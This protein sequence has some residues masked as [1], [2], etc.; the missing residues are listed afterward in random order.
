[1]PRH[2]NLVAFTFACLL[3]I[4]TGLSA[5]SSPNSETKVVPS[6]APGVA[7]VIE[8][9]RTVP[10][11]AEI[12]AVGTAVASQSID[13]ASKVANT[14]VA[15]RFSEG[16]RVNQGAVLVEFDAAEA[17]AEVAIVE[18]ELAE[19]ERQ[20]RRSLKLFERQVLSQADIEQLEAVVTSNRARLKAAQARLSDT[21]IRAP[22]G[23][24]VGLYRFDVGSFVRPGDVITTLDDTSAIK[25]DFTLPE[26]LMPFVE[27]GAKIAAKSVT[28]P[29][30]V[31]EGKIQAMDSRVDP[32]TRSVTVRALLP[33]ESGLLRPGLF[34]EVEL[35]GAPRDTI[36][37]PEQALIG[38]RGT[39]YV[40]VVDKDSRVSRREVVTGARQVGKVEIVSGISVGERI[41][42]D[43]VIKL[44]DG[45]QVRAVGQP[46]GSV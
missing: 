2:A 42:I 30:R 16:T 40:F 21:V 39:A 1:M 32:V 31:F 27:S 29:N 35:V 18:A 22:F 23:G 41:V 43:G 15:L 14:I 13:V 20:Y 10:F 45:M 6:A 28:L 26:R 7:V 4:C 9:A 25:L 11:G 24:I 46:S 37:I 19:S 34:M 5:C 38:E 12:R 44:R 33:N 3:A 8:V 17:E 36:V